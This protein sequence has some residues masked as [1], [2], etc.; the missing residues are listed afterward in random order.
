MSRMGGLARFVAGLI[1]VGLLAGLGFQVVKFARD[2]F[3]EVATYGYGLT[4][5]HV[6]RDHFNQFL[7]IWGV[8]GLY[9][10]AAMGAAV[11]A[12]GGVT[13]E[14]EGDTWTSLTATDLTGRDILG[15]KM[16]G[17]AWAMRWL[18]MPMGVMALLGAAAGALHP[19][20]LIAVIAETAVF[21]WFAAALGTLYSLHLKSTTKALAA[22][23]AT[24]L[25]LNGGYLMCC[26]PL[27]GTNTPLI[28]LGCSPAIL[29]ISSLSFEDV[30]SL[31]SAPGDPYYYSIGPSRGEL[32]ALCFLGTGLHAALALAFT[33][34][35][36]GTFDRV[37]DRPERWG[38][39]PPPP[40]KV[41]PP[42]GHEEG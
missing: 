4:G 19:F 31:F 32:V 13:G 40:E 24:L 8:T 38:Q 35:A 2:A 26:L 42:E 1:G 18:L 7:R 15:A 16:I 12:A 36:F 10:L 33:G 9:V 41:K 39:S 22:T 30:R 34:M 25:F 14:K 27:G 37:V 3:L 28:A 20:G 6:D 5:L 17:A 11:S 21:V 23:V 29:A